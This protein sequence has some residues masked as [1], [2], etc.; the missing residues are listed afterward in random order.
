MKS[1]AATPKDLFSEEN[2]VIKQT[3]IGID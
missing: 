3:N 1:M 2:S